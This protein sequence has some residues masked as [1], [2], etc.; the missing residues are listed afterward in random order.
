MSS[1]NPN[2]PCALPF[3]FDPTQFEIMGA[4]GDFIKQSGKYAV[5]VEAVEMCQV[6][7]NAAAHYLAVTFRI[8]QGE[9]KGSKF[10][11]R[12][13]IANPSDTARE[14]AIKKLTSLATATGV[15]SQIADARV[16]VGKTLQVHVKAESVPSTTDPNKTNWNNEVTE[17]FYADGNPIVRGQFGATGGVAPQNN[18]A[19][20]TPNAAPPAPQNTGYNAPPAP[21]QP[22]GNFAPPPQQGNFAPPPA[23]QQ[24]N[25]QQQGNYAPP[26][27]QTQIDTNVAYQP[28]GQQQQTPPPAQNNYAAPPQNTGGFTPPPAP[29]FAPPPQ[30]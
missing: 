18:F 20:N 2:V 11:E 24:Q 17:W 30:G 25:V 28:Q 29:Q 21:T 26:A 16:F 7:G 15:Q 23:Q 6:K 13:N 14:I 10:L 3:M 12:F 8:T 9:L 1:Y 5:V 22:Q 4:G 19:P 27:G